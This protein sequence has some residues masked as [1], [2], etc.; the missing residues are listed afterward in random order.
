[1][2]NEETSKKRYGI[3]FGVSILWGLV[4]YGLFMFKHG[5][6]SFMTPEVYYYSLVAKGESIPSSYD[7]TQYL[8]RLFDVIPQEYVPNVISLIT[9][10][11][12]GIWSILLYYIVKSISNKST[13]TMAY[14]LTLIMP[15]FLSWRMGFF[16]HDVI[17]ITVWLLLWS[18]LIKLDYREF[19]MKGKFIVSIILMVIGIASIPV[20]YSLLVGNM[21]LVGFIWWPF[22]SQFKRINLLGIPLV[23]AVSIIS[24]YFGIKIYGTSRIA[25]SLPMYMFPSEYLIQFGAFLLVIP[26]GILSLWKKQK[27]DIVMAYLY[28]GIITTF[29]MYGI[30]RYWTIFTIIVVACG[31]SHLTK[32]EQKFTW[33]PFVCIILGIAWY[34]SVGSMYMSPD[35]VA[36]NGVHEVEHLAMERMADLPSGKVMVLWDKYFPMLYLSQKEVVRDNGDVFWKNQEVARDYLA[37]RE[38][39]YLYLSNFQ[40]RIIG[41]PGYTIECG[42]TKVYPIQTTLKM[43]NAPCLTLSEELFWSRFIYSIEYDPRTLEPWF[44]SLGGGIWQEDIYGYGTNF[45]IWIIEVDLENI[46]LVEE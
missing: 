20:N 10:V 23:I 35:F 24:I 36:M 40:F 1:M 11:A 15:I 16:T 17:Q 37:S 22:F 9:I 29:F 3:M 39:R 13:A 6:H 46:H 41:E 45:K 30:I 21:I 27:N 44:I 42:N 2:S 12:L 43:P 19:S 28:Y 32:E 7:W 18:I 33:V 5:I 4:V 38:I 31:I 8:F 26:F 14:V 34:I 25:D